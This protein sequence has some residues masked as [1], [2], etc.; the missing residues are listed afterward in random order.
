MAH[1]NRR[2]MAEST[3]KSE[4][5]L[6]DRS[7]C[8]LDDR[9]KMAFWWN[10]KEGGSG[11]VST[12]EQKELTVGT[13]IHDDLDWASKWDL[14]ERSLTE[15]I[16]ELQRPG[17]QG[18]G[19]NA[20]ESLQRRCGWLV[21]YCLY[22]EPRVR[23]KYEDIRT[24]GEVVLDRYPLWVA[25]TPDRVLRDRATGKVVYREYKSALSASYKWM[26]SWKYAIQLH[27]GMK[28]LE[29]ELGEKI[30]FSQIMALM[31]GDEKQGR[32]HH[33]YVYGWFNE[34][35][36]KWSAKY[37]PGNAWS[38]RP[39]WEYE[40]GII[41]WV[42]FCGEQIA[43][44]QFPHSEPVFLNEVML[45]EWITARTHRMRVVKEVVDICRDSWQHRLIYFPPTLASCRPAYGATCQYLPICWN[46]E[47][48]V[49]PLRRDDFKKR[50]PHHII[51]L[52]LV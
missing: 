24:E 30:G 27:L 32:L 3:E 28:A 12:Q 11:I 34:G 20:Q 48:R 10:R 44:E 40:G 17:S 25:V 21:A 26:Q 31:K 47:A 46:A 4:I 16:N 29:E 18:L 39:T 49:D 37:M 22:L 45:D 23:E 19:L 5:L 15:R 35:T 6:T 52:T 2:F 13:E 43:I 38:P 50:E 14:S 7:G 36:Q 1:Y 41:E 9:C 33:P 8:E 42:K 51:E